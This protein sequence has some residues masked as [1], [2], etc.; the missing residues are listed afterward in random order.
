MEEITGTLMPII[1]AV[2]IG[3]VLEG[4]KKIGKRAFG[5]QSAQAQAG[6]APAQRSEAAPASSV[7]FPPAGI[8]PVE[9]PAEPMPK[10]APAPARR[11]APQRP[12]LHPHSLL[13]CPDAEGKRATA[14]ATEAQDA[15]IG[16]I[17][18]ADSR[19]AARAAALED[20]YARWRR[21]IIDTAILS[22]PQF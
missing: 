21:A 15:P 3:L 8:A 19:E 1:I 7:P 10:P 16:S 14:P 11:T 13:G 20:H 17:A 6:S 4:A 9:A 18:G 5:A 2:V 12:H 22:R